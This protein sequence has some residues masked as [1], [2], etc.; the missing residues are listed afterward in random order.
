MYL[1]RRFCL[2]VLRRHCRRSD[3]S[4]LVLYRCRVD[5][6]SCLL[7]AMSSCSTEEHMSREWTLQSST[8]SPQTRQTCSF[9]VLCSNKPI[10]LNPGHLLGNSIDL[11]E[12]WQIEG[13]RDWRNPKNFFGD[14]QHSVLYC[15]DDQFFEPRGFSGSLPLLRVIRL[16]G[17][18]V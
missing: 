13:G 10:M 18:L 3:T 17:I 1:P 15:I 4:L 12:T 2:D 14:F 8:E 16:S 9:D 5:H 6:H 7:L 11:E